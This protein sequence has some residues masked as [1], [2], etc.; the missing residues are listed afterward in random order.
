MPRNQ[1]ALTHTPFDSAATPLSIQ[2][3]R[4]L[5]GVDGNDLSDKEIEAIRDQTDALARVLIDIYLDR[6]RQEGRRQVVV[7]EPGSI[8]VWSENGSRWKQTS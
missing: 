8:P 3:C 1:R 2:R 7:N 4:E 5:L 6:R